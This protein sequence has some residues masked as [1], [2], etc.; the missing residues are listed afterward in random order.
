[1][2]PTGRI[3]D[4]EVAVGREGKAVRHERLRI[5]RWI[6]RLQRSVRASDTGGVR[7]RL[8][9]ERFDATAERR[10]HA[11]PA[12]WIFQTSAQAGRAIAGQEIAVAVEREPVRSRHAGGEG[13]AEGRRNRVRGELPDRRRRAAVGNVQVAIRVKCDA[14]RIAAHGCRV[15]NETDGGLG[16]PGEL[17]HRADIA[18]EVPAGGV[19]VSVFVRGQAL[20]RERRDGLGREGGVARQRAVVVA[21]GDTRGGGAA[22]A[23]AQTAAANLAFFMGFSLP[24]G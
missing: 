2:A 14:R 16:R 4:V 21:I 11:P 22:S 15:W 18:H 7:H 17:P 8:D 10:S 6:S 19:E 13:E 12:G 5:R 23:A 24:G 3:G 9:A 1:M 20:D